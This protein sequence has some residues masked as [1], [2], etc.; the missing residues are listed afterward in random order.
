MR[1]P[2]EILAI[3]ALTL[4]LPMTAAF[5][6]EI[7]LMCP[8]PMRTTIVELV[9]QFERTSPHKVTIVH[10]PSRMIIERI[11]DGEAFTS[12]SS[13]RR[14]PMRSKQGKAPHRYLAVQHRAGRSRRRRSP[15]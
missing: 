7:K 8:A 2:L 6:A 3:A 4:S 10:T 14:R 15:M 12:R 13:R 11:Q 1:R 9:A 5:A